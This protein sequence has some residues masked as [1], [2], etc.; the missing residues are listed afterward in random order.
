MPV[1]RYRTCK[2]AWHRWEQPVVAA[3]G[4]VPVA[5]IVPVF[6]AGTYRHCRRTTTVV[7][8]YH[9][10]KY[11]RARRIVFSLHDSDLPSGPTTY[12]YCCNSSVNSGP[13]VCPVEAPPLPVESWRGSSAALALVSHDLATKTP[14]AGYQPCRRPRDDGHG[15]SV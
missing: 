6:L 8:L 10:W 15:R 12:D 11:T 13:A 7:P 1:A 9:T 4:V 5:A 3:C 14:P 2:I